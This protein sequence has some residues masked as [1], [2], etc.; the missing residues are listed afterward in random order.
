L[1]NILNYETSIDS[2]ALANW[3]TGRRTERR[4]TSFIYRNQKKLSI[5]AIAV[6]PEH[7]R[8]ELNVWVARLITGSRAVV[9]LSS[10]CRLRDHCKFLLPDCL[11]M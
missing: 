9:C 5:G 6:A 11:K 2:A 4:D 3:M 1:S 7:R 8:E 10:S